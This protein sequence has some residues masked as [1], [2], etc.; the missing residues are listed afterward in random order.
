MFFGF[1]AKEV[2]AKVISAKVFFCNSLSTN[3]VSTKGQFKYYVIN[4]MGW[5]GLQMMMFD[6]K[7]GGCGWL[8]A[9]VS[10]KCF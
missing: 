6:D 10:K 8:N 7:V 1:F 4:E 2:T 5:W 3:A 9:D